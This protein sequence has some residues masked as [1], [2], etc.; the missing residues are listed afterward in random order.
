MRSWYTCKHVTS[1]FL[2]SC[3]EK[4]IDL[5]GGDITQ[6]WTNNAAACQI[7]CQKEN[8]CKFWTYGYD[9]A[10][11]VHGG[12]CFL[13]RQLVDRVPVKGLIS[14]RR[15]CGKLTHIVLF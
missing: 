2:D 15:N 14:G 3:S 6:Y 12:K 11:T 5:P 1:L 4:D 10:A 9:H 13:K 7:K 8:N